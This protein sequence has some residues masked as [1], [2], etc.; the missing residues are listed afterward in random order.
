MKLLEKLL[1]KPARTA[2]DLYSVPEFD[3]PVAPD[4]SFFVIGDVH[5]CLQKLADLLLEIEKI[6]ETPRVIVVGDMVDRG[7]HSGP[8]LSLLRRLSREFGDYVI[9]LAGNHEEMLLNFLDDPETAGNRWLR[10]G[11]LQT[12]ASYK[13]G[14]QPSETMADLALRLR[15]AMGEDIIAWLRA[16]PDSWQSGNVAVVHAGA[17]PALPL[18]C[19]TRDV[20]TWGHSEFG[21]RDRT[22]GIWIVH[23]HTIVRQPKAERGRISVDTGAYATG[24]LTAA[25]IR[26]GEV[27]FLE[28]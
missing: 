17:D 1:G 24:R 21:R 2:R 25:H 18:D 10:N 26:P 22:D 12:L 7:E 5:G 16:L 20:L 27:T 23:G 13:I 6:E 11:G 15:E 8:V 28:V 14:R 9:C 4:E 19:Q 3:A